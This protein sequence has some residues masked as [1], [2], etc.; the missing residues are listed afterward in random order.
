MKIVVHCSDTPDNREHTA[1][2]IHRWHQE[3][4]W[5]GIGYHWVIRRD[6]TIEPGR[7]EYWTGA[8]VKGHNKGSIGICLIGRKHFTTA[9]FDALRT[10]LNWHPE[11]FELFGHYELDPSKTCPNFNVKEWYRNG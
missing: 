8:H 7:P 6:G 5:D 3:R 1:A 2:D 9:Q 10:H 4:G 11:S